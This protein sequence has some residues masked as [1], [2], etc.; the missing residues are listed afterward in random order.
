MADQIKTHAGAKTL[1]AP[2]RIKHLTVIYLRYT[3]AVIR[4]LAN[5]LVRSGK[6]LYF[7]PAISGSARVTGKLLFDCI[8]SVSH[9]RGKSQS[10]DS[11]GNVYINCFVNL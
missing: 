8:C 10:H 11:E 4:Y 7:D 2:F 9:E 3:W 1:G 5:Y 6:S